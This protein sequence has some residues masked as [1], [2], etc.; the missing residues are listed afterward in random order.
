[1][2]LPSDD[3]HA[4]TESIKTLPKMLPGVVCSE[5]KKCGKPSCRCARGELHGPY[6][7]RY[8][9]EAGRLRKVYVARRDV[10]EVMRCCEARKLQRLAI[11]HGW[12]DFRELQQAI[13]E[14][15]L[16]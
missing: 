2:I 14:A 6:Y 7:Y 11:A 10:V 1:M 5:W 12:A 13:R 16:Q 15:L 9:R 3:P 4:E 8:W